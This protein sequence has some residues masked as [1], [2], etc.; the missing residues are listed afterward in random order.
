MNTITNNRTNNGTLSH[1]NTLDDVILPAFAAAIAVIAIAASAASWNTSAAPQVTEV[2]KAPV[3]QLER[4]VI[5]AKRDAFVQANAHA[6]LDTP[7]KTR[8]V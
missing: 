7:S 5:T 4:V 3:V 2:A 1:V 8:L 6:V